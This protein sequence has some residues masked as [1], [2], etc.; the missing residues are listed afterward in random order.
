M[1]GPGDEIDILLW[2]RVNTVL[3]PT[4][5]RNGMIQVSELGPIQVAGLTFDEAK[6]LIEYKAKRMTGV[7][8]DVTMGQLRTLN[9]T[10]AGDVNQP[11]SYQISALSRVSNALVAAGGVARWAVCGVSKSAM[12]TNWSRSSTSTISCCTATIRRTTGWRR[13][14]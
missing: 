13:V 10:V 14:T 2:G 12:A 1:I 4:V 6:K 3:N 8:V 5:D 9:I 11:G 7:Q